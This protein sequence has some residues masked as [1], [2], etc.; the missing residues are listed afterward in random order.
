MAKRQIRKFNIAP[1]DGKFRISYDMRVALERVGKTQQKEVKLYSLKNPPAVTREQMGKYSGRKIFPSMIQDLENAEQ[2]GLVEIFQDTYS[3]T[4][5]GWGEIT[6]ELNSTFISYQERERRKQ[7][8]ARKQRANKKAIKQL[9][10]PQGINIRT[11][12]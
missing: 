9:D 10:L 2:K 6:P 11:G 7:E 5:N 8:I 4:E 3:L 12:L 1:K